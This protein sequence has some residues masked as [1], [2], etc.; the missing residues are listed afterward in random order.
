[1]RRNNTST[2]NAFGDDVFLL[3]L[4][5]AGVIANKTIKQS[6]YILVKPYIVSFA[7]S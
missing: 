6:E 3:I 7:R 5:I 1:M 2:R 4:S